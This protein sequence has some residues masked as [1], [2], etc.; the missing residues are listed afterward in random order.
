[1]KI[2]NNLGTCPECGSTNQGQSTMADWCND[3]GW[4]FY[5]G[6]VK[7]LIKL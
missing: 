6:K 1:M 7:Q 3:C 2:Y 4:S 5:Y